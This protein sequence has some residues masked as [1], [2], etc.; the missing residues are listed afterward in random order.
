MKRIH[1]VGLGIVALTLA[2]LGLSSCD[3]GSKSG[4]PAAAP[5][6]TTKPEGD[7]ALLS[8]SE[9][10]RNSLKI[11]AAR[12]TNKMMQAKAEYTGWVTVAQGNEV[13]LTAPQSGYVR[14]AKAVESSKAKPSEGPVAGH[15]VRAKQELFRLDPVLTPLEELQL[16]FLQ[17][18]VAG[19]LAKAEISFKVAKND[20]TR[21]KEL[22]EQGLRGQQ[23]V[24]K[25]LE[26]FDH[27]QEALNAAKD[28]QKMFVA[29]QQIVIHAPLAGKVLTVH[30]SPGEFVSKGAPLVTIAD[31]HKLWVRVPV[32]EYDL[33]MVRTGESVTV[34]MKGIKGLGGKNAHAADRVFTATWV[35]K[36]PKVDLEKHTVDL[37]Y[38]LVP[39]AP[40]ET[41]AHKTK[42]AAVADQPAEEKPSKQLPFVKDQ[43]VSVLLPLS[44]EKEQTLVPY[45]AVVFDSYGGAWIY[46][47]KGE[48]KVGKGDINY[49]QRLAVQLGPTVG[50]E[51][52]IRPALKTGTEVVIDGAAKLF[53]SEFHS[54]P[55][56][57]GEDIDDDD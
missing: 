40:K 17:R 39:H 3:S 57:P 14:K 52:V 9:E 5:A 7:L 11:K 31:M 24:D 26:K 18:D 45:S 36:V 37:V 54:A 27:A 53:S 30:A 16:Q 13:T 20:L 47:D 22:K 41:A 29:Q 21:T 42:A 2:A 8:I 51:V 56:A 4:A 44:K 33:P 12:V 6:A 25:A 49:Y 28:K 35:A 23:E 50:G 1:F 46:L 32:P 19:E 10:Q 55:G 34:A 15:D 43:M 48:K 38:E